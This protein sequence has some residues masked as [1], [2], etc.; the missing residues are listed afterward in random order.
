V[1]ADKALLT[2]NPTLR[3][4]E[5]A[6]RTLRD[7]LATRGTDGD[8]RYKIELAFEEV[9]TNILRYG[10]PTDDI[11]VAIRF[12]D[13]GV[14]LTF[15]DDGVPFDPRAQPRFVPPPSLGET[16]IGGLGLHLINTV[17]TSMEY[18]RTAERHNRL[19]LIFSAR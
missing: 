14:A 16:Q 3:G 12:D 18:E 19:T 17:A 10:H 5:E 2:I 9:V 6:A 15:E 8:L 4:F 7:L 1:A 11:T 13:P